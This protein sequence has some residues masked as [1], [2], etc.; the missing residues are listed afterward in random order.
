MLSLITAMYVLLKP[1]ITGANVAADG[2]L[3][4]MFAKFYKRFFVKGK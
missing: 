1:V 2:A 4:I 3:V